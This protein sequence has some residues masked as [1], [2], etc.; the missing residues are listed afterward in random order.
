MKIILSGR[1][2]FVVVMKGSNKFGKLNEIKCGLLSNFDYFLSSFLLTFFIV[3]RFP[4]S[5]SYLN[6][7]FRSS[8]LTTV[9]AYIFLLGVLSLK[10]SVKLCHAADQVPFSVTTCHLKDD[11]WIHQYCYN[12]DNSIALALCSTQHNIFTLY[13]ID[14][15]QSVM[16]K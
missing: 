7:R 14:E 8:S 10:M 9:C 4:F 15:S 1:E 13:F 5:F 2:I 3:F 16:L 12:T 11:G 6:D